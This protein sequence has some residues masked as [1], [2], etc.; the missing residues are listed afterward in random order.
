MK[1][2]ELDWLA[3]DGV[4]LY[5]RMWEPDA[6]IKGTICLVHGLGEHS[7]RYKHWAD[8][9]AG[10][11]YATL[12]FDLRGHGRSGGRR[13]DTPSFDRYAD[14]I[15]ILI[16]EATNRYPGKPA[17]IYGHSLGGLLVL[18]YLVQRRPQLKGAVITS[19][20]LK[21]MANNQNGK[22]L[23]ARILGSLIPRAAIANGLDVNG[24]SRDRNV[25]EAY[26]QDPL[27]HDRISLRAGKEMFNA[28]E[29]VYDKASSIN[30]PVLLMHGTADRITYAAGSKELAALLPGQCTLK[31]WDGYFHELHNEPEKE[32]VFSFLQKW[33]DDQLEV[34]GR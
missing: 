27:V 28:I 21:T 23:A 3:E 6:R 5:T 34:E 12:S 29:F 11:G 17:F 30:L 9:L 7:G 25:V 32:Q 33:L 31:L 18:Y 1:C 22:I 4:K 20:G 8:L 26:K 19:P 10:A 14:D 15:T 13:G 16:E 24:L 2:E